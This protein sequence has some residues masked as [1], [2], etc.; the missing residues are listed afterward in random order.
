MFVVRRDNRQKYM[1]SLPLHPVVVIRS[2][3]S[4][5]YLLG[6]DAPVVGGV[7]VKV[8]VVGGVGVVKG[9]QGDVIWNII[10]FQ[11]YT[12]TTCRIKNYFF[13]N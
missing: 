2:A 6:V 7:G 1:Y 5:F 9:L 4:E 12:V 8:A 3:L 13:L 11:C 10:P